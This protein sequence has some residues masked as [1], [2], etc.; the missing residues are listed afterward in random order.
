MQPI[1]KISINIM[2]RLGGLADA[3]DKDYLMG[4]QVACRQSFFHSR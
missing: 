3:G 4:R 2:R 1:K